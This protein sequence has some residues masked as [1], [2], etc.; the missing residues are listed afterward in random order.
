MTR[1]CNTLAA[2]V[3]LAVVLYCAGTDSVAFW[4][5]DAVGSN[6]LDPDEGAEQVGRVGGFRW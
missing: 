2:A 3:V 1:L 6:W 4:R 5:A